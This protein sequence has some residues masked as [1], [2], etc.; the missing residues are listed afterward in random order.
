MYREQFGEYGYW[1]LGLKG[2]IA[3]L[4]KEWAFCLFRESSASF[5]GQLINFSIL[6]LSV[7][8][9]FHFRD[10]N[11]FYQF[12]IDKVVN[13]KM[14]DALGIVDNKQPGSPRNFRRRNLPP[15]NTQRSSPVPFAKE[16]PELDEQFGEEKGIIPLGQLLNLDISSNFQFLCSRVVQSNEI[17]VWM[18]EGCISHSNLTTMSLL[19]QYFE[20]FCFFETYLLYDLEL[21]GS[22][23]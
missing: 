14:V 8:D 12:M 18:R 15:L 19:H 1:G 3:S 4:E 5:T 9:E 17:N 16:R 20:L 22:G 21:I 2:L 13:K 23:S 6:S 7:T 11:I 10:E